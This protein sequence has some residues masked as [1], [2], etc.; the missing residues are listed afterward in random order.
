MYTTLINYIRFPITPQHTHSKFAII[1]IDFIN[2]NI[3]S[4][5]KNGIR[6]GDSAQN[7]NP[8][9]TTLS[10]LG[11]TQKNNFCNEH[12]HDTFEHKIPHKN[13]IIHAHCQPLQVN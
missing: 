6:E 12:S 4:E 5:Y 11:D 13:T 3:I 9:T 7:A 1:E 10:K 2:N 8:P